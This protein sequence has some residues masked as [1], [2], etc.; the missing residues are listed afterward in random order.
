MCSC[1]TLGCVAALLLL[2]TFGGVG[3]GELIKGI[4]PNLHGSRYDRYAE[5]GSFDGGGPSASPDGRFIVYSS[6]RTNRG[7]IYRANRDGTMPAALTHGPDCDVMPRYSPDGS[8]IAFV[9]ETNNIGHIWLMNA[10]GTAQRQITFGAREDSGPLFLTGGK[11]LLFTRETGDNRQTEC[12]AIDIDGT[13]LIHRKSEPF[14]TES[15]SVSGNLICSDDDSE[16]MVVIGINGSARHVIGEGSSPTFSPNGQWIAFPG[17]PYN[18]T[19]WIMS[20]K[21]TG[22]RQLLNTRTRKDCPCF[23][24]DGKYVLFVESY[25]KETDISEVKVDG[26]GYKKLLA[27]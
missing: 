27:R 24:A 1:L 9:R 5:G 16:G 25:M 19:L 12:C 14:Y 22:R 18:Q 3:L 10:D 26:S 20:A 13:H 23:S 21:E 6:P 4:F 11:G 15:A 2:V 7:D 17:E 8:L